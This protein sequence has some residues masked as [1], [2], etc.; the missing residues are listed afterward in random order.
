MRRRAG[1]GAALLVLGM[2]LAG[3]VG[4]PTSGSVQTAPIDADPDEVP[5]I[6]LP[7]GPQAGQG[8]AELLQGFLRAGRGPQNSYS[9]AREFLAPGADWSGTAR[10]LVSSSAIQPVQV[11]EDTWS[12]TLNV[13]AEVDAGGRYVAATSQQTLTYDF[14]QVDGEYRIAA[15]APG[16]VLSPSGFA[17]AFQEYPVYFFDPSFR[18]LVPDLRW[19]P[20]TR[21]AADRIVTELLAGPS[22]WLTSGVLVSAFPLGTS[23]TADYRAPRVGV[24]LA[25]AVRAESPQAQRRM[26]QQLEESLGTLPNVTEVSVTA[27][28]LSLAP[29]AEGLPPEARYLVRD[30]I[31]GFGGAFG[32]LTV[33][34]VAP[35]AGI[36]TRA[37]PLEPVQGALGRDRTTA[38]LLGSGGVSLI[39]ESGDPVLVDGRPGL[40]APTID[41]FGFV[42]SVPASDPGGLQAVGADGVVHPIPLDAEGSVIAIELAR[43]GARLLVALQT[44]DGPRVFVAGV[45]RDDLAPVGL[46]SSYPLTVTGSLIDVAWLDEVR[47]AV[48]HTG[49]TG[50]NV[51]VLALGGPTD[52]L[53]SVDDG[54]QIVGGNLQEGLRVL[55]SSGQVLRPSGAGGW[56]DTG[57]VASFLGTQQ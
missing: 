23:G 29:S 53:G 5:Q 1:L 42:W 19:F 38:A 41:P 30:V 35:L 27:E 44:P 40:V 22:P 39:P 9:V 14:V 34:G 25:G 46:G 18:Y 51:D 24:D 56:V 54:I 6:A 12:V 17:T 3:C 36:G 52:R 16:T 4:I 21:A 15:A 28:G 43:D 55:T 32:T 20:A 50:P 49:D 10:V 2:L 48:L 11:D 8:M 31:G 26:L 33:D 7:E 47:V 57:L 45:L 37:N 13:A